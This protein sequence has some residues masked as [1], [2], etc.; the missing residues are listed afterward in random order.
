MS[1]TIVRVDNLHRT[2]VLSRTAKVHALNGVS[3]SIERGS[4]LAVVGESGSGKSTLARIIVG[5][6]SADSGTVELVG[7]HVKPTTSRRELRRRAK[8]GVC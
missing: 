2:F 7:E 3:V 6:E 4:C 5:L 8:A 1:N